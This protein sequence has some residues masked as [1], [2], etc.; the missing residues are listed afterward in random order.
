MWFRLSD[1]LYRVFNIHRSGGLVVTWQ[2]PPETAAR[3][4]GIISLITVN[5]KTACQHVLSLGFICDLRP[6]QK[7]HVMASVGLHRWIKD[8][9][10]NS[11]GRRR[12]RRRRRQRQVRFCGIIHDGNFIECPSTLRFFL[13]EIGFQWRQGGDRSDALVSLAFLSAVS[14]T[15]D[16]ISPKDEL[17]SN[18]EQCT[19]LH[20]CLVSRDTQIH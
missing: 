11:K 10:A 3:R 6:Y 14:T 8:T 19:N 16:G 18:Q 17:E 9:K 20:N 13:V 15:G 12:R 2:M 5:S 1:F 7:P 4:L